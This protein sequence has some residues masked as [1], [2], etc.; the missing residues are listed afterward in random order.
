ST[1]DS[2]TGVLPPSRTR[3]ELTNVITVPDGKTVIIGGLTSRSKQR[4]ITKIPLLGDIPLLG[5]LF[6]KTSMEWKRTNLYVFI[7]PHIIKGPGFEDL[8]AMS[9]AELESAKAL[10]IDLD[11]SDRHYRRAFREEREM[12]DLEAGRTSSLMEY[13]SP[14]SGKRE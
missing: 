2:V 7:T 9:E 12:A 14:R 13:R 8:E 10:G 6:R 11:G 4:T 5:E 3:R 1:G